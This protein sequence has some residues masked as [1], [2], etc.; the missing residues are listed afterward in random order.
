MIVLV[1][2]DFSTMVRFVKNANQ[3]IVKTVKIVRTVM[4]PMSVNYVKTAFF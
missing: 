1:W 4:N 2:M 3:K